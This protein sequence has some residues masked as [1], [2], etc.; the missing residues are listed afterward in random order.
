[1]AIGQFTSTQG[2][3]VQLVLWAKHLTMLELRDVIELGLVQGGSGRRADRKERIV[4][5]WSLLSEGEKYVLR[6]GHM[7]GLDT[8]PYTQYNLIITI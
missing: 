2:S 8:I 4:K 7:K 1:M 5:I 3:K 6:Q